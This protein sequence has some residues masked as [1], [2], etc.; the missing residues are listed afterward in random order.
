MQ[1]SKN[2]DITDCKT[3]LLNLT[4]LISEEKLFEFMLVFKSRKIRIVIFTFV[5]CSLLVPCSCRHFVLYKLL[6]I[7]SYEA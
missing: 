1:V 5:A 4:K 7:E 2:I 3:Y 6:Y